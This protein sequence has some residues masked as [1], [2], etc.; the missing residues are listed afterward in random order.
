[1]RLLGLMENCSRHGQQT[2]EKFAMI[3]HTVMMVATSVH[4]LSCLVINTLVVVTRRYTYVATAPVV[5]AYL[6]S[7]RITESVLHIS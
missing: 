2:C 5:I 6:I 1:M 3:K 4:L 7:V